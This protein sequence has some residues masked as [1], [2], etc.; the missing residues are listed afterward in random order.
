[1]DPD[2]VWDVPMIIKAFS[3]GSGFS[4]EFWLNYGGIDLS[5]EQVCIQQAPNWSFVRI[6]RSSDETYWTIA[7]NGPAVIHGADYSNNGPCYGGSI[8][9]FSMTV[10]ELP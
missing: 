7:S 6:K 3:F 1:M 9:D 2:E 5:E 4:E 8:V 10:T